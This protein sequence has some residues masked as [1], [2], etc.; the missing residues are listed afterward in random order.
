VFELNHKK[1]LKIILA[2]LLT[3]LSISVIN[4]FVGDIEENIHMMDCKE[5]GGIPK[6]EAWDLVKCYGDIDTLICFSIKSEEL[7]KNLY[8]FYTYSSWF[9]LI[10]FLYLL[11][12]I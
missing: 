7:H 2:L 3:V 6:R 9:I 5:C 1:L 11:G 10:L 4:Y 8:R 12:V